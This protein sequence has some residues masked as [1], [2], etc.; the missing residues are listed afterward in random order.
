MTAKLTLFCSKDP[1]Y[2]DFDQ[3]NWDIT[4]TTK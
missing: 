2:V 4:Q 3:I 1:L